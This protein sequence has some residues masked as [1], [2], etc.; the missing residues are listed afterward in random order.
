MKEKLKELVERY[1]D[2]KNEATVGCYDTVSYY[3]GEGKEMVYEDVIS[4][5]LNILKDED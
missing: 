5:L 3:R 2:A 1:Y 4:D